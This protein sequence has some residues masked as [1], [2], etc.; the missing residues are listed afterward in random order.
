MS[1]TRPVGAACA[2]LAACSLL[3]A[4]LTLGTAALLLLAFPTTGVAAFV[5]GVAALA[6]P[7]LLT[8]AAGALLTGRREGPA[9]A[10]LGA[11]V[12]VASAVTSLVGPPLPGPAPLLVVVPVGAVLAAAVVVVRGVIF[13]SALRRPLAI[14]LAWRFSRMASQPAL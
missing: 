5:V 6:V 7:G 14:C 4:L 1:V 2:L 12:A 11:A 3:P 9:L 13:H 10:V 8:L